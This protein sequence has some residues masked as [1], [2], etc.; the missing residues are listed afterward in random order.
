MHPFPIRATGN[1]EKKYDELFLAN[2]TLKSWQF[3]QSNAPYTFIQWTYFPDIQQAELEELY[4]IYMLELDEA[5]SC[6]SSWLENKGRSYQVNF[7]KMQ[8]M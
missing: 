8:L 4:Y 2:N 7:A 5:R 6:D 1:Q 3:N